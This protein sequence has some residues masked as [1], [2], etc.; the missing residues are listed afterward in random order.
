[1]RDGAIGREVLRAVSLPDSKNMCC[2]L[3]IKGFPL[4]FLLVSID[5][6]NVLRSAFDVERAR[7]PEDASR[8][9]ANR[10]DGQTI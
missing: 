2:Q 1:M 3:S 8:R 9:F 7:L 6:S 4:F 10:R 5:N